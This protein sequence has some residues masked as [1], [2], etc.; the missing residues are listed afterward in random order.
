MAALIQLHE[1]I[2][3]TKEGIQEL[4]DSIWEN[5]VV[6]NR[7][8]PAH[9][10]LHKGYV[11]FA[12]V[13]KPFPLA[14]KETVLRAMTIKLY[15]SEIDDFYVD[16]AL[17]Q[18]MPDAACIDT[19]DLRSVR[20]GI[21]S[22]L[23]QTL[24]D[25]V[26]GPDDD[27]FAAGLDSLST[28]KVLASLRA[29]LKSAVST[30]DE[31]TTSLIYSNPTIEKLSR[32]IELIVRPVD[33]AQ[34]T[35]TAAQIMNELLIKYTSNLPEKAPST[36]NI[37]SASPSVIL[38][39]STGSL[40]SYL[41]DAL[42]S[43][44]K[45]RRVFCLNRS[46]DARERQIRDNKARGLKEDLLSG[47]VEFLQADLAKDRFGLPDVTYDELLENTTHIIRKFTSNTLQ[48]QIH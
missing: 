22:L 43:N 21:S 32:A 6:A 45:V 37:V 3:T 48:S 44:N 47:R 15:E 35:T 29:T 34:E 8:A 1:P 16:Q 39:G 33:G 9:G 2:P 5:M 40:G 10:Q 7:A 26:L 20:E 31:I 42:L 38:T 13:N 27:F 11:L 30:K 36:S 46:A 28:S 41:L 24:A 25:A 23:S 18:R 12:A 4:N 17:R 19:T 14:G